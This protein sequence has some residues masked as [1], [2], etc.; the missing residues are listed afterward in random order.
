MKIKPFRALSASL[1]FGV[2]AERPGIRRAF[3]SLELL[4]TLAILGILAALLSPVL[5][6]ARA[7]A[8]RTTCINNVR[9]ISSA[10][11]MYAADHGDS[12]RAASNDFHI[13]FTYRNSIES[14][15]SRA[16]VRTNDPVFFCPADNFDCTKPPIQEVFSPDVVTGRGLYRLSQTDFSSYGL[17]GE[18]PQSP[19]AIQNGGVRVTGKPFSSV[20][21]PTRLVLECEFSGTLGLS[22]HEPKAPQPF[23]DARNVVGFVDGHASFIPIYWNGSAMPASYNPPVGYDYLWFDK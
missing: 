8:R 11:L 22:A 6:K 16:G 21:Q 23:N 3:T 9:Q 14:Y 12:F 1:K 19:D 15:L 7:A 18:A 17:N 4:V 2:V 5:G 10:V 20:R 13:Y